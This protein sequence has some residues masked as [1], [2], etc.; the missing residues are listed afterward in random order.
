MCFQRSMLSPVHSPRS[1]FIAKGGASFVP[2]TSTRSK[3]TPGGAGGGVRARTLMAQRNTEVA[4]R[5]V[6]NART[7]G[8]V[9]LTMLRSEGA[10]GSGA[11]VIDH[12][13]GYAALMAKGDKGPS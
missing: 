9:V 12:A 8:A 13:C 3:F 4:S 7:R 6:G 5:I 11:P 10:S 1:S 2:T